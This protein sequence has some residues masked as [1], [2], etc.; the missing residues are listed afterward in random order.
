MKFLETRRRELEAAQRPL[1]TNRAMLT[2]ES[3]PGGAA[4]ERTGD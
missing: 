3:Q 2:I 4:E 1:L